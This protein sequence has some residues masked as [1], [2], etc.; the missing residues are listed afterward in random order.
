[1][2]CSGRAQKGG[3]NL[4]LVFKTTVPASDGCSTVSTRSHKLGLT[5]G[6]K[7][8]INAD[9]TETGFM[10]PTSP[11]RVN[12][13]QMRVLLARGYEILDSRQEY[14]YVFG[15]LRRKQYGPLHRDNQEERGGMAAFGRLR[16]CMICNLEWLQA[17]KRT[18]DA[19]RCR[20]GS[21]GN[22]CNPGVRQPDPATGSM[23]AESN[24]KRWMKLPKRSTESSSFPSP[25]TRTENDSRPQS[26]NTKFDYEFHT[27]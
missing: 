3:L 1:M 16:S 14:K 17:R 23:E 4:V 7:E 20:S 2:T 22:L 9:R 25:R 6:R 10:K 8:H 27:L 15:D 21:G 18:L 26:N 13:L 5:Q 12:T 24:H 19:T 11:E